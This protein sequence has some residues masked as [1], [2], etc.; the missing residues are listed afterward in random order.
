MFLVPPSPDVVDRPA[1][2]R[3]S[4]FVAGRLLGVWARSCGRGPVVLSFYTHS[5]K[6]AARVPQAGV[7]SVDVHRAPGTPQ[8]ALSAYARR[9][10]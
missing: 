10:S 6:V 9:G 7:V 2:W 1:R 4:F 5:K 3:Q 8:L